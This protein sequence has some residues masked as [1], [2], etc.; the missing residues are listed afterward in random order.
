M[1]VRNIALTDT[2]EQFRT[3]FNDMCL[4][5]FG[6]IGTLDASMSATSVIGAVN[7]LAGQIFAA[8]GWKMEDSTST[9]QQIGAGQ[10]AV[11]K[12]VSNQT[13]AVVS[14]PDIL[15]IGLTNVVN[16]TTSLSSPIVSAG[17]MTLQSGSILDS[18]GTIDFGNENITT[19]GSITANDLIAPSITTTGGTNTLG[20]VS[21]VGNTISSTDS[22]VIH[23]NDDVQVEGTLRTNTI[24]ARTGDSV[25]FG[26]SHISTNNITTGGYIYLTGANSNLGIYFEGAT[27]DAFKT[28]IRPTDPTAER[29]VTIPDSTGTVALTNTTGYA[30]GTLFT[31]SST[32]VI[33]NS[34]GVAQK[35][36]VGSA[37]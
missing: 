35:T 33:Y 12:G 15:T 32:L 16:I 36:I 8:E 2:L 10:T 19:T 6:D 31:S 28:Y 21:I 3:N 22:T 7:E 25:S 29:I 23:I 24:S 5:D 1:A 9:V 37:T 17:T 18:S 11:F 30:T 34:A 26:N 4:N 20:T 27:D 13:T 14:V